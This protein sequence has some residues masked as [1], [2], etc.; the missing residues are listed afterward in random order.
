MNVAR[1]ARLAAH[2]TRWK[3]SQYMSS[4]CAAATAMVRYM[5]SWFRAPRTGTPS[6]AAWARIFSRRVRI[7]VPKGKMGETG[8]C[9]GPWPSAA[10]GLLS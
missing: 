6:A 10:S 4:G 5:R 8:Q 3:V 9:G 7:C 2:R 1:K